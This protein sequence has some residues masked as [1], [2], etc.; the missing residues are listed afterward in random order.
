M[1]IIT[2]IRSCVTHKTLKKKER[3]KESNNKKCCFRGR[4]TRCHTF[5]DKIQFLNKF[6]FTE[7]KRKRRPKQFQ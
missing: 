7:A 5:N 1:Q 6:E 3:K 4:S 2:D